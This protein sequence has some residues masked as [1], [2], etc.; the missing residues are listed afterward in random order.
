MPNPWIFLSDLPKTQTAPDFSFFTGCLGSPH[1]PPF[2][3]L[4][5]SLKFLLDGLFGAWEES[6][7]ILNI[8]QYFFNRLR[9]N[10][11]VLSSKFIFFSYLF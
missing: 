7:Q 10:C 9:A 11:Q 8:F 3:S 1:L 5:P 6:S 4:P 2:L